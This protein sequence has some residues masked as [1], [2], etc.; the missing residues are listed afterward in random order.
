MFNLATSIYGSRFTSPASRI[1][2]K[3]QITN[4]PLMP[5]V[6]VIPHLLVRLVKLARLAP[7]FQLS[8]Y[9]LE[10]LHRLQTAFSLVTFDV[11]LHASVGRDRDFKFALGHNSNAE[12]G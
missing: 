9:L 5:L 12:C 2:P 6:D 3:S 8:D 1:N 7:R 10:Y 4:S 11:Q